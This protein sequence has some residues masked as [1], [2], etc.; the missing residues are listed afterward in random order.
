MF[1]FIQEVQL[2]AL[3]CDEKG[4]KMSK[5]KGNVVDPLALIG[6]DHNHDKNI[7]PVGADVLRM[8][9]L[10]QDITSQ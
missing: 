6:G 3:V 9:L 2:H 8:A 4:H 5:S 1:C 7:K 10:S